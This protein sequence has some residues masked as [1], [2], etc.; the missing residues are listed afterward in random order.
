MKNATIQD[1]QV[2]RDTLKLH[3]SSHDHSVAGFCKSVSRN[4]TITQKPKVIG[5]VKPTLIK[6]LAIIVDDGCNPA[7]KAGEVHMWTNC[8]IYYDV[9]S[10]GNLVN[11]RRF[12]ACKHFSWERMHRCVGAMGSE[13]VYSRR[14]K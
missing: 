14:M 8:C 5:R 4:A 6:K 2:L 3:E 7:F 1:L 12:P 10:K 9:S 13:R 11:P